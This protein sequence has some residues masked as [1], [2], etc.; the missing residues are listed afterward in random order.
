VVAVKRS[1]VPGTHVNESEKW[2][3]RDDVTEGLGKVYGPMA[4]VY[5]LLVVKEITV[6]LQHCLE[7]KQ[8]S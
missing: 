1:R 8:T 6:N 3:Q 4:L 7:R 2:K 5:A